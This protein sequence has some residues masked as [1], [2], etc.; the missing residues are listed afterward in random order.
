MGCVCVIFSWIRNI[1]SQ[2]QNWAIYVNRKAK[3]EKTHRCTELIVMI[4]FFYIL[5]QDLTSNVAIL[6]VDNYCK[7][8]VL[9]VT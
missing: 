1:E 4:D 6:R 3:G 8:I 2:G 7:V 9:V 5:R